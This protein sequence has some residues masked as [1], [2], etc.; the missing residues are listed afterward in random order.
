[1][2]RISIMGVS[3]SLQVCYV[4]MYIYTHMATNKFARLFSI[5]GLPDG[6]LHSAL[7][8]QQINKICSKICKGAL[9]FVSP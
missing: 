2:L 4:C 5:Y 6:S 7:D 3:L 9:M 1:M 8:N